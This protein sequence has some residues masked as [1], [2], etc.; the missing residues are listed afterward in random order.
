VD[1]AGVPM[2]NGMGRTEIQAR[3]ARMT[4]G[5]LFAPGMSCGGSWPAKYALKG[6]HPIKLKPTDSPHSCESFQGL[7]IDSD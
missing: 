7:A 4:P 2:A 1:G 3:R 5:Q 6:F